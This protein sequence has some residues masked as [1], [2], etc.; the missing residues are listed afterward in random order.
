MRELLEEIAAEK[1]VLF[2][3]MPNKSHQGKPV[4]KL[5]SLQIYFDKDLVYKHAEGRWI[6]TSIDD[7]MEDASK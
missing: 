7:L 4:Y 1:S 6:P 3:P 2:M 5:G